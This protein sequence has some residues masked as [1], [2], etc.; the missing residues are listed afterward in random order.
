MKAVK[1]DYIQLYYYVWGCYGIWAL[2]AL[3]NCLMYCCLGPKLMCCQ[4]LF[5]LLIFTS[6]AGALGL[7]AFYYFL[8]SGKWADL[9]E[10]YKEIEVETEYGTYLDLYGRFNKCILIM[11]ICQASPFLPCCCLQMCGVFRTKKE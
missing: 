8:N 2:T 1:D 11:M 10:N 6:N 4:K 5:N 9:V 7:G 3:Y